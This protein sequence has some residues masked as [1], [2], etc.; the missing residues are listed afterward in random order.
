M[1]KLDR[2]YVSPY[3]VNQAET[4]TVQF[5]DAFILL[6]DGKVSNIHDLV[7]CLEAVGKA[8][9]PLLIIAEDIE[10]EVLPTL[11]VNNTRGIVKVAA[12]KAPGFGDRRKDALQEIATRTG[13]TVFSQESGRG[14]KGEAAFNLEDLGRS[15]YVVVTQNRTF[16]SDEQIP[17]ENYVPV[18]ET[19]EVTP[20]GVVIAKASFPGAI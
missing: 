12:V 20:G 1:Y 3:F 9:T 17:A 19:A 10:G 18:V 13:A 15:K 6:V 7:P 11:V 2:G 5:E 14:L 4:N 8:G 16:L